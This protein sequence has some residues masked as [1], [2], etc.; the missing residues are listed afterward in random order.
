[1]E[2]VS[3]VIG[4][5]LYVSVGLISLSMAY[6]NLIARSYLPFHEKA[7]GWKWDEVDPGLQAVIIALMK[8]VGAG[9]L[10]AGL[11][12]MGI[13]VL[14]LLHH[15]KAWGFFVPVY[16]LAFIAALAMANL[17]LHR[18]TKAM[19]PWKASLWAFVIVALGVVLSR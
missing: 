15:D 17:E 14:Q 18:R 6:K 13:A 10:V 8:L 11:Q 2:N 9:F 5:A 12:L 4:S 3:R 7:A 1:M 16:S 19:T